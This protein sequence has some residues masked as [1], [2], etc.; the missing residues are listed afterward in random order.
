[1][2]EGVES[3]SLFVPPS[4]GAA[5]QLIAPL[6]IYPPRPPRA[7][8]FEFDTKPTDGVSQHVLAQHEA[9]GRT[10]THRC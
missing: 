1:M 6:V 3:H 4:W 5:F 10:K 9:L 7:S 2:S 8:L